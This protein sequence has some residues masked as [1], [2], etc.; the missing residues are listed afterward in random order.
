MKLMH[1]TFALLLLLTLKTWGQN[2]IK[3]PL[4]VGTIAPKFSGKDQFG[5]PFNMDEE[6]KKGDLVVIFYRGSWCRYCNKHLGQ[7]EDSL[8]FI[9]SKGANVVAITPEKYE[10]IE[11]TSK[12]FGDSFRIIR[13]E[14]LSIMKTYGVEYE[15]DDKTAKKYKR[16][17]I[18]LVQKNGENGTHLPVPATYIIKQG[19]AIS[20]VFFDEDYKNR[21]PISEIANNL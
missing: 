11:E 21:V 3:T 10:Y 9:T 15:L 2:D 17:G 6:L 12:K 20:Y 7:L 19:G 18:D 16:F 13:D 4:K 14:D 5:K 1:T 8:Q